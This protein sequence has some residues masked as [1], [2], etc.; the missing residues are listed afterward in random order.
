MWYTGP[1]FLTDDP[2]DDRAVD[3]AG[4]QARRRLPVNRVDH[5][6]IGPGA[7]LPALVDPDLVRQPP[8]ARRVRP[9]GQADLIPQPPQGV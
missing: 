4:P 1:I 5:V 2:A 8:P 3:V 9:A 7:A 6:L